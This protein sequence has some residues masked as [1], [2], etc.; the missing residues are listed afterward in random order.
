MTEPR[1][2]TTKARL[3]AKAK[4]AQD[5]ADRLETSLR[6][7]LLKRKAQSRARAPVK[8]DAAAAPDC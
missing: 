5:R 8:P 1:S 3:S 7:N 6:A 2:D 4:K